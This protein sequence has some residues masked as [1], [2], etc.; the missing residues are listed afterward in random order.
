MLS[1]FQDKILYILVTTK[2]ILYRKLYRNIVAII[3]LNIVAR[4][5]NIKINLAIS[6]SPKFYS[7]KLWR[8]MMFVIYFFSIF[9]STDENNCLSKVAR[10]LINI[11]SITLNSHNLF[12]I[13]LKLRILVHNKKYLF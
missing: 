13:L 7:S 8:F 11:A 1:Y 6:C 12:V 5:Y 10:N 2:L 3:V 9:I 4:Q